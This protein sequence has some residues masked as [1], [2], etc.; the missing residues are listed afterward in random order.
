MKL[1]EPVKA[2]RSSLR[3]FDGGCACDTRDA[4]KLNRGVGLKGR[5]KELLN[6]RAQENKAD[7]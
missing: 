3:E 1:D 6:P 4:A 5:G 7:E 2:D